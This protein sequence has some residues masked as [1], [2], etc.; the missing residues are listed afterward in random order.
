MVTESAEVDREQ[1]KQLGSMSAAPDG[2]RV[3]RGRQRT[4][5]NNWEVC[6]PHQMVTESAEVDGEQEKQLGSKPM[7]TDK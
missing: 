7:S 1:E 4:R 3:S 5:K 2:N 6:R